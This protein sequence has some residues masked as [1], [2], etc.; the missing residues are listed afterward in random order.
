MRKDG[1][2]SNEYCPECVEAEDCASG[3]EECC[4]CC[5]SCSDTE[6]DTEC[7]NESST[8]GGSQVVLTLEQK[9]KDLLSNLTALRCN[10]E[11]TSIQQLLQFIEALTHSPDF[12]RRYN[13]QE[14]FCLECLLSEPT[15]SCCANGVSQMS[16]ND[17]CRESYDDCSE[18]ES[19][20][21]QRH[22]STGCSDCAAG[23]KSASSGK[24]NANNRRERRRRRRRQR[25]V[26]HALPRASTLNHASNGNSSTHFQ[27]RNS[28]W[29][30]NSPQSSNDI[31][32]DGGCEACSREESSK[33]KNSS[34][35]RES[36][37]SRSGSTNCNPDFCKECSRENLPST[38]CTSSCCGDFGN[39]SQR[40][41]TKGTTSLGTEN[42]RDY[43]CTC[44]FSPRNVTNARGYSTEISEWQNRQTECGR[45]SAC[46]EC[47]DTDD[48]S[49]VCSCD[50]CQENSICQDDSCNECR[51]PASKKNKKNK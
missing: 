40:R 32:Q 14:D 47:S 38:S 43:S 15:C 42:A 30:N 36:P 45:N 26:R 10:R 37:N 46:S 17:Q 50:E 51:N 20:R 25:N 5:C 16:L 48:Q 39:E 4:S 7:S 12:V 6:S 8:V 28:G 1:M 49:G 27:Q 22:L 23:A 11:Q 21:N 3:P 19:S 44:C 33:I 29:H 13:L 41:E 18:N 2:N 9:K 34:E 24:E 35:L 31:Q